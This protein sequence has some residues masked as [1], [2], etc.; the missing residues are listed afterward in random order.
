MSTMRVALLADPLQAERHGGLRAQLRATLGALQALGIEAAIVGLARPLADPCDL[1]HVFG[2]GEPLARAVEDAASQALP[3]VLSPRLAPGWSRANGS[4]A[5]VADRV[6]GNRNDCD[7]DSGYAQIRR[8][9][10]HAALVLAQHEAERH[11]ICEAF[12]VD[13][14]KVRVVPNGVSARFFDA[15]PEL[16]RAR[17]HILGRF[18]LMVGRV[19]PYAGQ[20]AV[21][22]TLAELAL[23]LVVIGEARER[24]CA[25][26]D[27]LR[28]LRTVSCTGPLRHEDPLLASAYAAASVFVQG[29]HVAGAMACA[30]ALAAG[31]PVIGAPTLPGLAGAGFAVRTVDRGDGEML[32]RQVSGLLAA[33]PRRDAV[34]AL[35]RH[36]DWNTVGIALVACY[37]AALAKAS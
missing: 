4:R 21:A 32:K 20:L 25:Y 31:T 14:A 5:R 29:A 28:S 19:S 6:F 2:S 18:A 11:A 27:E 7:L 36:L 34:R 17:Q 37:R 1:L 35:V 12:L 15:D 33:P 26:L 13:P 16:F 23:P 24:D 9:L 30:E 8:A 10:G 3:V 22:R